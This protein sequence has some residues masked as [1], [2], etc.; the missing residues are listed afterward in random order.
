[1][2]VK[3]RESKFCINAEEWYVEDIQFEP[4]VLSWL[5]IVVEVKLM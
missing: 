2:P 1:M 3:E 4:N 5:K